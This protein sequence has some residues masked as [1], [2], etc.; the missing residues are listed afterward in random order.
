[1]DTLQLNGEEKSEVLSSLLEEG[2]P[3][4]DSGA[5]NVLHPAKAVQ[6]RR[7]KEK[8]KL[9]AQEKAAMGRWGS[10]FFFLLKCYGRST[11]TEV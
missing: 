10:Y 2:A 7:K 11:M 8:K 5:Q 9:K 3:E 1:M 4:A 6:N